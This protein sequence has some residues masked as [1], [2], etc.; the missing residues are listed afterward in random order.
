M[1]EE[2]G[3]GRSFIASTIH[4]ADNRAY[5]RETLQPRACAALDRESA[6]SKCERATGGHENL[7]HLDNVRGLTVQ[8]ITESF[9][10]FPADTL[11]FAELLNCR[12]GQKAIF[13][14]SVS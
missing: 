4:K 12:L 8:Q 6:P 5:T 1:V 11:A 9:E 14:E 13:T 3:G 7:P 2:A 10:I